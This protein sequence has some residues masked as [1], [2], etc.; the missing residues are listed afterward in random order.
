MPIIASAKKKLR[1][2]KKR[3]QVNAKTRKLY[4]LALKVARLNTT[5]DTQAHAFS[6]L[7][8]AAKKGVIHKNKANRLK[9]SLNFRIR[10]TPPS[11]K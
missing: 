7:D 1:Q 9:A 3:E 10:K 4:K 6:T 2:D 11:S 8:L 5:K